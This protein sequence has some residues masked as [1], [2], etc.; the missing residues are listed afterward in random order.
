MSAANRSSGIGS[1]DWRSAYVASRAGVK[2]V[3]ETSRIEMPSASGSVRAFYLTRPASDKGDGK[4]RHGDV[5]LPRDG[6]RNGKSG[7]VGKT[8]PT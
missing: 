1:L 6:L 8:L 7:D 4:P 5:A 2:L 3:D